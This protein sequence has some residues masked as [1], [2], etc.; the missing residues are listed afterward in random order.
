M[1]KTSWV[2]NSITCRTAPM[3]VEGTVNNKDLK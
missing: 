2:N 3:T 1:Y